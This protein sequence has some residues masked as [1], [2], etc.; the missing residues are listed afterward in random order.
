MHSQLAKVEPLDRNYGQ[1]VKG[2]GGYGLREGEESG[3]KWAHL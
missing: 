1:R 3:G 2:Y